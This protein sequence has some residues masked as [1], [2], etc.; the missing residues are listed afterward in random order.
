MEATDI[1]I[2]AI[3]GSWVGLLLGVYLGHSIRDGEVARLEGRVGRLSRTLW[4]LEW[5][6][7]PEDAAGRDPGF[8]TFCP[9]CK[10]W[11]PN[12]VKHKAGCALHA[13]LKEWSN[14]T[15]ER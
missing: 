3:L 15:A 5:I 9:S 8:W 1:A 10:A 12:G 2:V 4:D 11:R 13:R 7:A 14:D 6:K